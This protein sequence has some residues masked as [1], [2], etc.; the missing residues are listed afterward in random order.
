VNEAR[1]FYGSKTKKIR[2]SVTFTRIDKDAHKLQG[3]RL[4]QPRSPAQDGH[5]NQGEGSWND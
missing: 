1:L 5:Q 4:K 3:D 2:M